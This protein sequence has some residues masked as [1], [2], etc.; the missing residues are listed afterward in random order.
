MQE[1]S[2]TNL[3]LVSELTT[4][5]CARHGWNFNIGA[6]VSMSNSR[7]KF[8]R[9]NI[10]RFKEAQKDAVLSQKPSYTDIDECVPRILRPMIRGTLRESVTMRFAFLIFRPGQ[11]TFM[12]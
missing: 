5:H 8:G 9:F 10:K 4:K 3:D 2:T 12:C 7:E 1:K 6:M 11:R